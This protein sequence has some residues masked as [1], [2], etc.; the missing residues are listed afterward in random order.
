M[1]ERSE[2]HKQLRALWRSTLERGKYARAQKAENEGAPNRPS[3]LDPTGLKAC[4]ALR[5][6]I[7]RDNRAIR[8]PKRICGGR[9][10][11]KPVCAEDRRDKTFRVP[12]H[13]K[14]H[15]PDLIVAQL[16]GYLR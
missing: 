6:Y 8:D 3:D 5:T 14:R 4:L 9:H 11:Q 15:R 16:R 7:C 10:I 13:A 2:S 12:E 1:S